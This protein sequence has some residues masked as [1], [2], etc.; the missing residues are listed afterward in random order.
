M[1]ATEFPLIIGKN[2]IDI[3]KGKLFAVMMGW[4]IELS[5]AT[6]KSPVGEG[7]VFGYGNISMIKA[8]ALEITDRLKDKN[9]E[10]I[11]KNL[12]TLLLLRKSFYAR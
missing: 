1:S 7:S 8:K 11:L 9:V 5:R 4:I 3:A 12:Y 2:G 6:L 10:A